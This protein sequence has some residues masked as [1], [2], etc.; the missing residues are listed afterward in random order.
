MLSLPFCFSS[1]LFSLV[2]FV[3][4]TGKRVDLE[5]FVVEY[6]RAVNGLIEIP[7]QIFP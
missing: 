7:P 1:C 2:L 4:V 3:P 5:D 6:L